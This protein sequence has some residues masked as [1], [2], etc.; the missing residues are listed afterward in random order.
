[1]TTTITTNEISRGDLLYISLLFLC[2]VMI[3]PPRQH[4]VVMIFS[5]TMV[6]L[7]ALLST[8]IEALNA[9]HLQPVEGATTFSTVLYGTT[10]PM[11]QDHR[12]KTI[13]ITLSGNTDAVILDFATF[14]LFTTQTQLVVASEQK[15]TASVVHDTTTILLELPD[16]TT[17]AVT[18]GEALQCHIAITFTSKSDIRTIRPTAIPLVLEI[19]YADTPT[20]TTLPITIPM[21]S[22]AAPTD[23]F[24]TTE[25]RTLHYSALATRD[26]HPDHPDAM[27]HTILYPALAKPHFASMDVE[28]QM[29][30]EIKISLLGPW[31][32]IPPA[33]P[34][35]THT[36][37]VNSFDCPVTYSGG[38]NAVSMLTIDLR[39]CPIYVQHNLPLGIACDDTIF[40]PK[41]NAPTAELTAEAQYRSPHRGAL[42]IEVYDASGALADTLPMN[43]LHN[44]VHIDPT[45][46][47]VMTTSS[48][49]STMMIE[50]RTLDT[51]HMIS[52]FLLQYPPG[53]SPDFVHNK[54]SFAFMSHNLYQI[55]ATSHN[56]NRAT[57]TIPTIARPKSTFLL[58]NDDD[59]DNNNPNY[60]NNNNIN[61]IVYTTTSKS[62][63]TS[64]H[65]QVVDLANAFSSSGVVATHNAM[66]LVEFRG[67]YFAQIPNIAQSYSKIDPP[68]SA[69][70]TLLYRTKCFDLYTKKDTAACTHP[71][72]LQFDGPRKRAIQAVINKLSLRPLSMNV[73]DAAPL[74]YDFGVLSS[75]FYG[76]AKLSGRFMHS[77]QFTLRN[78]DAYLVNGEFSGTDCMAQVEVGESGSTPFYTSTV[79]AF[80]PVEEKGVVVGYGGYQFTFPR[81]TSSPFYEGAA[82]NIVCNTTL[83]RRG[84][85]GQDK[86]SVDWVVSLMSYGTADG[87]GVIHNRVAS[88]MTWLNKDGGGSADPDDFM[89]AKDGGNGLAIIII[90]LVTFTCLAVVIGMCFRTRCCT[91]K[92]NTPLNDVLIDNNT[93]SGPEL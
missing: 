2:V 79:S 28:D 71:L 39:Q 5:I 51:Y 40:H 10:P 68:S 22:T 9:T 44:V 1:M 43:S 29:L 90:V 62:S 26:D 7:L 36:C 21:F 3:L 65:L 17:P 4:A 61:P 89:P 32:Y 24:E 20:P 83:L 13:S 88:G 74:R 49:N 76:T 37:R 12:I 91:G 47:P 64:P 63:F 72:L 92:D 73:D 41:R 85:V 15:I 66:L 25:Q 6:L 34:N 78:T 48:T 56:H 33:T 58:N 55:K 42:V 86:R 35:T 57:I 70:A 52:T 38:G 82:L 75:E 84:G 54:A 50:P 46:L 53:G 77:F 16:Q 8:P 30:S 60:D 67:D 59:D 27:S 69:A 81:A 18:A 19:H 11:T 45:H 31:D 93:T 23:M 87:K 80:N 14:D